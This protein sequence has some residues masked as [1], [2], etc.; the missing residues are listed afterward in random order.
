MRI[1]RDPHV[2]LPPSP[3]L[4]VV[5]APVEYMVERPARL[6]S[7]PSSRPGCRNRPVFRQNLAVHVS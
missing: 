1:A 6:T 3:C 5:Q 4:T 7:L 2:E